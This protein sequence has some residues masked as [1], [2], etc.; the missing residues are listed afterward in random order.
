MQDATLFLVMSVGIIGA[1]FVSY[2]GATLL[3]KVSDDVEGL[4]RSLPTRAAEDKAD[5]REANRLKARN[6]LILLLVV[7][8]AP[9]AMLAIFGFLLLCSLSSRVLDIAAAVLQAS[10]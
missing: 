4:L 5:A 7:R 1:T 8:S 2:V 10:P 9:G 6:E 3:R